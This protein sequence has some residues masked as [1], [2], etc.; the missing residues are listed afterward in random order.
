MQIISIVNQMESNEIKQQMKN[1]PFMQITSHGIQ[2]NQTAMN[3]N[4]SWYANEKNGRELV[5]FSCCDVVM[6]LLCLLVFEEDD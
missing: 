4:E 2:F 6:S 1:P 3:L 5:A